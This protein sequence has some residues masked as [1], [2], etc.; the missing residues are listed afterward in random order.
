MGTR[1]ANI[2]CLIIDFGYG[3]RLICYTLKIQNSGRLLQTSRLLQN[4]PVKFNQSIRSGDLLCS[5][6][7]KL[8][9][10]GHRNSDRHHQQSKPRILTTPAQRFRPKTGGLIRVLRFIG[11]EY[12]NKILLPLLQSVEYGDGGRGNGEL[13]GRCPAMYL[14]GTP[15]ITYHSVGGVCSLHRA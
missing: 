5:S 14:V 8:L 9:H 3:S 2:L 12:E 13:R 1:I 4:S 7:L 10:H 15:T 11:L 6:S